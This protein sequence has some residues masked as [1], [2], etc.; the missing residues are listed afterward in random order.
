LSAHSLA[1]G[2]GRKLKKDWRGWKVQQETS[3]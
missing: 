2:P 3:G 1:K